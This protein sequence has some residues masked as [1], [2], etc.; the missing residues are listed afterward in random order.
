MRR[1]QYFLITKGNTV[2]RPGSRFCLFFFALVFSTIMFGQGE[3]YI[4][5]HYT[6]QNGLPANG[7]KGIELDKATGFLWVGTQAGLVRFDGKHFTDFSAEKN[8]AT[9]FR[10]IFIAQNRTGTIYCEDDN[11][12]VY[13]VR[14][15]KPEFVMTDTLL[16]APFP[17]RGDAL[18]IAPQQIAERLKR[19]PR[20]SFL[21]NW[22]VFD[23]KPHDSSSFTFLYSGRPCRYDA[24]RDT[25]IC[26]KEEFLPTLLLKVD[27]H[28]YFIRENLDLWTYD[29]SLMQL[30]PVPVKGMPAWNKSGNEKPQFIW[31]PGMKAP[32]LVYKGDMWKL[33]RDGD[34]LT[35]QP[36]CKECCPNDPFIVH[37]QIWEEQ[38][39]MFLASE[40]NGLYV[41]RTPFVNTIRSD[42]MIEA[43]GAEY[44]QAEITPGMITTGYGLSFSTQGK[45]S[46]RKEAMEF[47]PYVIYKDQRDDHWFYSK[48]SIIRRHHEDGHH[49]ILPLNSA[50]MVFAETKD[51]LYVITEDEIGRIA[52]DQYRLLYRLPHRSE[53]LKNS[54]NPDAAIE[55]KPGVLAIAAENLIFFNTGKST[56]PDTIPIPGLTAKVRSLLKYGEYLLIGTYGQG[57]YMYKNGVVK[58][59]PLDKRRYL[60]TTH[61]FLRDDKGYCWISSNHGLFKVSL[62]ALVKAYENNLPEIYYHYFGREDGIFSTEFNGGCQPCALEMSN[63]LYSF[64]TMN[65]MAVFDP[66]RMQLPL[67]SGKIFIDEILADTIALVPGDPYL[68]KLPHSLK[69]LRFSLALPHFGNPENI[70]FSY[71]LEPYH[72]DW[73]VQDIV[74]NNALQ[75][76]RLRPGNYKLYLR[77]R[78]GFENDQFGITVIEFRVL[79]PWYQAGWFYLAC[80]VAFILVM[81]ALVRWRTASIAMRKKQLQLKVTEQTRSIAG[82]SRQLEEQLQQMEEDNRIKSRLIAIISHDLV[83]PLT[84]MAP[85]GKKLRDTF[86]N[87]DPNYK[88]ADMLVTIT[89]ELES[90][91]V[92]MLNWI[93]FHHEKRQM[94]PQRFELHEMVDESIGIIAT[95]A[96]GKGVELRNEVPENTFI[97]QY[98][99]AIAVIVYNLAMNAMKHTDTGEIKIACEIKDDKYL[100][101]V[102]DTG[103]GMPPELV[104]LLN[105]QESL[106]SEYSIGKSKKFQFGY[107]IVRDLL[108]MVKGSM[109]VE[110]EQ[111]TGTTVSIQFPMLKNGQV[112]N[113]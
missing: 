71:K 63:G 15:N 17:L 80:L 19:L 76:D 5:Q 111:G 58:K 82:Q 2:L 109:K 103:K 110:S 55:W 83:T 53:I 97:E 35:L 102:S 67:P 25:L 12:S 49:T 21:L 62:D 4:I 13:R 26:F 98:R 37:A 8:S 33:Q 1:N 3:S 73:Q 72:D 11:F 95:L 28:P 60:S 104:N 79:K 23:D 51:Q 69:S 108:R 96:A 44:A 36:F 57:F 88:L 106:I 66:L 84:F 30:T 16:A 65:G 48:G 56:K 6:N 99:E 74:Q 93:R 27:G 86:A 46:Y 105:T 45:L 113:N 32:L 90:L 89:Q 31:K 54:F 100:L 59:M 68:G 85:V 40:I 50:K 61:C 24:V 22:M 9:A 38:G 41:V 7:I 20:S 39:I 64:P 112:E 92:N 34:A 52:N 14:Q 29:D 81:W 101:T 47:F 10:I 75:F 43:G 70:Y 87:A 77:V 18:R 91:T 42:T 94:Q 78:N 107:R